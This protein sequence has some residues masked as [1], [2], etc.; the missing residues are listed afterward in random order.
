MSESE[1]GTIA[2]IGRIVSFVAAILFVLSGL[3]EVGTALVAFSIVGLIVGL[4]WTTGGL[5]FVPSVWDSLREEADGSPSA[6][7]YIVYGALWIM[8]GSAIDVVTV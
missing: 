4:F 3:I 5:L 2:T 6:I 1:T 8:L 7:R